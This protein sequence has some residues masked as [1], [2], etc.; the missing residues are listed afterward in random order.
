MWLKCS[1][2][3]NTP[4][5][6]QRIGFSICC[7]LILVR[8]ILWQFTVPE[9]EEPVTMF[10]T[11]IIDW[12]C[13]QEWNKMP[14]PKWHQ[15]LEKI[16]LTL[17]WSEAELRRSDYL[18]LVEHVRTS[19]TFRIESFRRQMFKFEL[20]YGSKCWSGPCSVKFLGT[21]MVHL[22]ARCTGLVLVN[23][24]TSCD[25]RINIWWKTNKWNHI[26]NWKFQWFAM[27]NVASCVPDAALH[28]R[29]T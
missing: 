14:R 21:Q 4:A 27:V 29:N 20:C 1:S 3:K 9:L 15:P 6:V 18:S 24:R 10:I 16:Q 13:K 11:L 19:Y 25:C 12:R 2:T 5:L 22:V 7:W 26:V 28:D 23:K 17:K 8:W